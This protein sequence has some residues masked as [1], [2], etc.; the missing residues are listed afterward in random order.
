MLALPERA[1]LFRGDTT[2][3][4]LPPVDAE[5]TPEEQDTEIGMSDG[6]TVEVVAGLDSGDVVLDK[7]IRE[8][9]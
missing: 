2:Y 4:R 7:E 9:E 6:L 8:I 1:L 3:V 5:A